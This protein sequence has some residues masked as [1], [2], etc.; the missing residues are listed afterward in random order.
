[1][2]FSSSPFHFSG[3]AFTNITTKDGS[4]MNCNNGG[5]G[6]VEIR[7]ISSL[8]DKFMSCKRQCKGMLNLIFV[9]TLAYTS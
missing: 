9:I 5:N 1:M 8:R 4:V 2:S 3:L 6:K 7:F